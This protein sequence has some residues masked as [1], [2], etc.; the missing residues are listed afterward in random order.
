MF[1][2]GEPRH[3]VSGT[4]EGKEKLV[5]TELDLELTAEPLCRTPAIAV[6]PHAGWGDPP[7]VGDSSE[8][9]L[10]QPLPQNRGEALGFHLG[11]LDCQ[12]LSLGQLQEAWWRP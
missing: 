3:G 10:L 9:W 12:R 11:G 6:L 8:E 1:P 7:G 5:L 2:D 4:L